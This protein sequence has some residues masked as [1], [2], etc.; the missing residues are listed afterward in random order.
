MARMLKVKAF[1]SSWSSLSM[2]AG[3]DVVSVVVGDALETGD[4]ADRPDGGATDLTC[5][6]GDVVGHGEELV[7]VIVEEEMIVAEVRAAHVPV[8]VLGL[9]VEREGIGQ[10]G[11]ESGGDVR[12][13]FGSYVRGRYK[14]SFL[15][16]DKG[17]LG[18][19]VRSF[20]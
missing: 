10:E 14:G 17:G 7:A 9:D 15:A 8:E 4:V 18:C 3:G 16:S 1:S 20:S 19:H 6:L 11:V 13:V 12:D 2:S 5:S